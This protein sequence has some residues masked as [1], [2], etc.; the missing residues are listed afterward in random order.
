MDYRASPLRA[1]S[2]HC[3]LDLFKNLVKEQ[4][5]V[6]S[7]IGAHEQALFAQAQQSAACNVLGDRMCASGQKRASADYD[8]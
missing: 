8:R 1:K 3:S 6:L 4:P 5:H 7:L 2:G